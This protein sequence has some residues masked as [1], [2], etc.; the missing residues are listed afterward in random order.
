MRFKEDHMIAEFWSIS[1]YLRRLLCEAEIFLHDAGEYDVVVTQLIR[2]DA[3]QAELY[4]NKQTKSKVSV[5]Q[6]GRGADIRLTAPISIMEDL[7]DFL[8]KNYTYDPGRPGLS[9]AILH[10]GTAQHVHIQTAI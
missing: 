10:G 4:K 9:T 8:C 2:S 6:F 1:P 5:H 7:V 3:E